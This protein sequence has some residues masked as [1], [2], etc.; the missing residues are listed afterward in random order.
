MIIARRR[1]KRVDGSATASSIRCSTQPTRA[2]DAQR[3]ENWAC[4]ILPLALPSDWGGFVTV[5]PAFG[6]EYLGIG[7][8]I[9]CC[10]WRGAFL[11]AGVRKRP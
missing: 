1:P 6:A 2:R 8:V 5:M 4:P 3:P 7:L 10:R 9:P 11:L